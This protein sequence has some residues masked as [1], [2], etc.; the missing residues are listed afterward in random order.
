MRGSP[1]TRYA[2]RFAVFLDVFLNGSHF[3]RLVVQRNE[4]RF[5]WQFSPFEQ[6]R[7]E[8]I[9]ARFLK[10]NPAA[11]S[12]PCGFGSAARFRRTI[13]HPPEAIQV[14]GYEC[15]FPATLS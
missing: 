5:Y 12:V 8:R 7:F 2:S 14:H 4:E 9:G 11:L 3:E 6:V 13:G 10:R 15:R 1:Y